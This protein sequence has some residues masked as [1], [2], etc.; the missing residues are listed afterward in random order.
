MLLKIFRPSLATLGNRT[1]NQAQSLNRADVVQVFDHFL[2]NSNHTI[3]EFNG[4]LSNLRQDHIPHGTF[5]SGEL[6]DKVVKHEFT[7]TDPSHCQN[8]SSWCYFEF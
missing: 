2:L 4:L 6:L 7:W 8:Q 1:R 3:K 5:T